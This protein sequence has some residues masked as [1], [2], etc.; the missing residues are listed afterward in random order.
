MK[1]FY[2]NK[3]VYT[4]H[5]TEQMFALENS[6]RRS[7]WSDC[8]DIDYVFTYLLQNTAPVLGSRCSVAEGKPTQLRCSA[9]L[10]S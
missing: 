5:T 9:K 1:R 6:Q 3:A 2:K 7:N 8:F 4:Y 10:V